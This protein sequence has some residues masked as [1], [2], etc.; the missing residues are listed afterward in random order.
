MTAPL[1]RERERERG[2]WGPPRGHLG[3]KRCDYYNGKVAWFLAFGG[4]PKP[5]PK[6]DRCWPALGCLLFCFCFHRG[7][8]NMSL[9]TG[10]NLSQSVDVVFFFLRTG[11][12]DSLTEMKSFPICAGKLPRTAPR[13]TH[14]GQ[15]DTNP[16]TEQTFRPVPSSPMVLFENFNDIIRLRS[17]SASRTS[18]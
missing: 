10:G 5:K 12:W 8:E 17:T 7:V 3:T 16:K 6:R 11:R 9:T 4:D 2:F 1:E 14:T 13:H 18:A 15:Q